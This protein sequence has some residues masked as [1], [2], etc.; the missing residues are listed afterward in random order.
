MW[1]NIGR[2][3]VH[4]RMLCAAFGVCML[5]LYGFHLARFRL[6]GV[7]LDEVGDLAT[8]LALLGQFSPHQLW[9][10]IGVTV[11]LDLL[12][13]LAY[14]TLFGGLIA[15]G[16]GAN[17]PALL[18]PLAVLVGFDLFENLSQLALLLLTLLQAA[19]A[20]IEIIAAFKALVTPIKFSMLYLTS[21]ISVMAV[22]SLGIQQSLRLW[23]FGRARKLQKRH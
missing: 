8:I 7:L 15:R 3:P 21:A 23:D 20:T 16:F 4:N 6:G 18:V 19:P 5:L 12:F 1:K 2:Y 11:G 22:M 14:A 13:P 9:V 10:H 17:S